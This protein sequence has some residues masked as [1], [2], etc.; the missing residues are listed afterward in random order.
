MDITT[1]YTITTFK[2]IPIRI[3]FGLAFHS[4]LKGSIASKS[5]KLSL[6]LF[7]RQLILL[8]LGGSLFIDATDVLK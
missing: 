2:K 5:Q 6:V 4:I 1:L 3:E 8:I 7:N